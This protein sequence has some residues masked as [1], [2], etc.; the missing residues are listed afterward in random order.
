VLIGLHREG[1]TVRTL[2]T[3]LFWDVMFTDGVVDVFYSQ[4]QTFPLDFFTDNF[5]AS[6]R[7]MIEQRLVAVSEATD[8][9]LWLFVSSYAVQRKFY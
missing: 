9:V 4:F 1:T 7:D 5:Y 6:R 3:L 8:E 2:F